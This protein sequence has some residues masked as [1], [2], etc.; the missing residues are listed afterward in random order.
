M[1]SN[2]YTHTHT[3]T[4]I[5]D[6]ISCGIY[7]F[8]G[9]IFP[10]LS[11]AISVKRN[12][13]LEDGT[14][15]LGAPPRLEPDLIYLEKDILPL[16]VHKRGLFTYTCDAPRDFWMQVKT[17]SSTLPANRA[18]LQYFMQAIPRRLTKSSSVLASPDVSNLPSPTERTKPELIQPVYIHPSAMV[19]P[20]AKI[21]PNVSIGPRVLV[22]RGVRIRDAIILDNTEVRHDACVLNAVIGAD[23]KVGA[24]ARVEGAP[25]SEADGSSEEGTAKGYKIPSAGTYLR[26]FWQ[27]FA[28]FHTFPSHLWQRS[29]RLG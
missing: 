9:N 12:Q 20:S 7:I 27:C 3:E 14:T 8:N 13:E 5:S 25:M 24:W 29:C 18:T 1:N 23:S 16:L 28:H 15:P 4:H 11:E 21:G 6:T 17:G 19:H 10:I 26:V 22:S 2:P